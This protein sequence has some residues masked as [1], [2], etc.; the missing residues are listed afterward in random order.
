MF[1]DGPFGA[2]LSGLCIGSSLVILWTRQEATG[3]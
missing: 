1:G 2:Y 3:S